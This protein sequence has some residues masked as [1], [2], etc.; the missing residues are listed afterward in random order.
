M[1]ALEIDHENKQ[2]VIELR[3]TPHKDDIPA[4]AEPAADDTP[5]KEDKEIIE[6]IQIGE[7]SI[8][9]PVTPNKAL[10]DKKPLYAVT[11]NKFTN[12]FTMQDNEALT[13]DTQKKE[14]RDKA[15]THEARAEVAAAVRK[16]GTNQLSAA[17]TIRKST[18]EQKLKDEAYQKRTQEADARL[19]QKADAKAAKQKAES[20]A[21][22][23]Q[24][25]QTYPQNRSEQSSNRSGMN[26][27]EL[28][29]LRGTS[30]PEPVSGY[31]QPINSINNPNL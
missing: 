17:E 18:P 25:L 20:N 31:I 7:H 4:P 29:P 2:Y 16:A 19:K 30:K 12:A 22:E 15:K 27:I 21:A 1:P 6:Y 24:Y 28:I 26:A 14:A 9:P 10:K 11:Y 5:P 3:R 23:K 8:K 13:A